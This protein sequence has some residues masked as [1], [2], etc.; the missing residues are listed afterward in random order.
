MRSV[1]FMKTKGEAFDKLVEYN[2][3]VLNKI[4]RLVRSFRLDNGTQYG[5]KKLQEFAKNKGIE[6]IF[7][8]PYAPS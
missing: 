5:V 2:Q 4:G 1:E 3:R 8:S 6:M 7:A